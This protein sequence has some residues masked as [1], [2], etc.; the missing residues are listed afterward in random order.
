[1]DALTIITTILSTGAISSAVTSFVLL[2]SK[3]HKADAEAETVELENDKLQFSSYKLIIED[4]NS[5]LSNAL[6]SM[7]RLEE[8]LNRVRQ[9]NNALTLEVATL[10]SNNQRLAERL[11]A[12]GVEAPKTLTNV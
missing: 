6:T 2:R 1:M 9:Q 12:A 7:A 3:K 8:E 10:R 11:E 5:R 4:L